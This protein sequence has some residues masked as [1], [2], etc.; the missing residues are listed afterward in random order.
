MARRS[1]KPVAL[2]LAVSALTC[3]QV[4][5][6][7]PPGSSITLFA[8]PEFIPANGGVSVISALVF[9]PAGTPVADGTVV[10]FF[11]NLGRID[12]QG[13]TN[14]GVARVNLVSDS[15]S[16]TA[17]VRAFS[18]GASGGAA[19]APSPGASPGTGTGGTSGAAG[20]VQVVIG[21]ALP[22][23]VDVTAFPQ[24]VVAEPR[25]ATIRAFVRDQ[26]G[27]PVSNEP[28]LFAL[29]AGVAPSP[30]PSPSPTPAPP[31]GSGTDFLA[32][33]GTPVFTDNNGVAEDTL[34]VRTPPQAP[35]RTVTITATTANGKTNSASV[36]IN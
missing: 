22:A 19:P 17:T 33:R 6:T 5:L 27:N 7:A 2:L 14:D 23:R 11:T 16:G 3:H 26:N 34:I 29:S 12:E 18:G 9:E 30:S 32:S 31:P 35:Q 13:R 20:S 10:Q 4:I 25:L 36:I 21:S 28:V 1:S 24:R 15:R 8:N